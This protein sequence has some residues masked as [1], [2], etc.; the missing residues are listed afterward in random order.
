VLTG[1]ETDIHPALYGQRPGPDIRDPDRYRDERDLAIL[2]AAL[3]SDLPLLGVCRGT[4][5]LNI[6]A[7]GDLVQD[8]DDHG[9]VAHRDDRH[10]IDIARDSL[11]RRPLG[12]RV[13]VVSVHHQGVARLGRGLRVAARAPDGL[14]EALEVPGRRFAI[15][16]QWHPERD[17][18]PAAARLAEA[19]VEAA[20]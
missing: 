4:Q 3:R 20:A 8:L 15:G 14:V 6:L 18:N 1:S 16:V 11:A 9:P 13:G 12:G 10:P 2:R 5:L 19:L 17:R 7:G